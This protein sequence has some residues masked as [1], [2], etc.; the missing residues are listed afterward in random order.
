MNSTEMRKAI[1]SQVKELI[2][3]EV[4]S[5]IQPLETELAGVKIENEKLHADLS[6]MKDHFT[7]LSPHANASEQYSRKYN[8]RIGGIHEVEG[9][10]CYAAVSGFFKQELGD[11]IKDSDIDR[12]RRVGHKGYAPCQ[13]I[14]KFKSYRAKLVVMKNR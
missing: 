13:M 14:I 7:N 6:D 8:V 4:A 10:D 5:F 12:A 2:Q 3:S 9:E 11:D 1:A